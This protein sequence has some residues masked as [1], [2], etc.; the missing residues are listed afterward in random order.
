MKTFEVKLHIRAECIDD[1]R[2]LL[3]EN[4]IE[5]TF[6]HIITIDKLKNKCNE[7]DE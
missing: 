7:C 4:N 1:A 2:E 5:N 3:E 6:I